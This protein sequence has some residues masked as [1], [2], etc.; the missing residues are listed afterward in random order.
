MKKPIIVL[1]TLAILIGGWTYLSFGNLSYQDYLARANEALAQLQDISQGKT[2]ASS[3]SF[4]IVP[5]AYADENGVDE[6]LVQE[7]VLQVTTATNQAIEVAEDLG[8]P[9]E[10]Q[11]AL[12]DIDKVQNVTITVLAEVRQVVDEEETISVIITATSVTQG[13]SK[14]I[15]QALEIVKEAIETGEIEVEIDIQTTEDQKD[16]EKTIQEAKEGKI[17]MEE[18]ATKKG[19]DLPGDAF[20]KF[21]DLI[22]RAQA[23]L[24][25][26]NFTE[27]EN[28]AEQAKESLDEVED[29]IGK[30]K[31]ADK[32]AK[33]AEKEI[34]KA[35]KKI[36]K[37][38]EKK[39]K[40]IQKAEKKGVDLPAD[41]FAKFDSLLAQAQAAL[42]AGNY[43][44]AEALA[45][46]AEES[47]DDTEDMTDELEKEQDENL[48]DNSAEDNEEIDAEDSDEVEAEDNEEIDAEDSDEV[49]AEDN[50][51]IDAEDSDGND[52]N[53]EDED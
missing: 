29:L 39:A 10:V 48:N 9:A 15:E 44:L 5:T 1:S 28:L 32:D 8:N 24:D 40:A 25:A 11:A 22:A 36:E 3:P 20:A 30:L 19:V 33:K 26:E 13:N 2:V 43:E 7:L 23:A 6:T 16:A 45:E 46:Q 12:Q 53:E 50:E 31:E 49:E 51:E 38:F 14:E 47:L 34:D 41:A 37:A 18:K 27:A 35:Q 17:K 4:E 21:D 52:E 42:D